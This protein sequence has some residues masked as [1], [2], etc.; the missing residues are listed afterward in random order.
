MGSG[1]DGLKGNLGLGLDTTA[2]QGKGGW[3]RPSPG[4]FV[5]RPQPAFEESKITRRH[6]SW[7]RVPPPSRVRLLSSLGLTHSPHFIS[8]GFG[9]REEG[10]STTQTVRRPRSNPTR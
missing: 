8:G 2:V 5:N 4:G 6:A 10:L 7:H 1:S 9:L 3:K